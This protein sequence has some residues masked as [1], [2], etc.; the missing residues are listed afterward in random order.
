MFS[1]SAASSLQN[2]SRFR[3]VA[4]RRAAP[5]P[6]SEAIAKVVS[7]RERGVF[8]GRSCHVR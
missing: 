4:R 7:R 6:I 2:G 1:P 3:N 8:W 5:S